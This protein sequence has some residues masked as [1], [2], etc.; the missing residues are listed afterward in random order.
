MKVS[1][2]V[3]AYQAE[4]TLAACLDSLRAQ[5]MDDIE[6]LVIDDG[7]TDRTGGIADRVADADARVR[8]IHQPNRGVS[9]AR[10]AGILAAAG[11]Y[12]A[13]ADADDT[14]PPDA[15]QRLVTVA[16]AR[17]ADLVTGD[18]DD[19]RTTHALPPD[20]SREEMLSA[21]VRCDGRYNAVW[22]HLYRR[23][24][25]LEHRLTLPEGIR[26]GEDVLF[27]LSATLAARRIAHTPQVVYHY[28]EQPDSAMARSKSGVMAAH[29]PMLDAM[30]ALLLRHRIKAAHYRDFLELHAGLR[31]RD[32]Q[33]ALLPDDLRRVNRGI[34]P[35]ALPIRQ[36]ALWGMAA[37]GLGGTLCRRIQQGM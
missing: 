35:M 17:E 3:P 33:R 11:E 12:I 5:T 22:A 16:D 29:V 7:S 13:F 1:V 31:H 6:V 36:L 23:A 32:G 9:A 20:I 27:N 24:F 8:V 19:G 10:N 2:I 37:L 26:I 28:A 21:L 4:A 18:Y 30:D 14:L 15:L 25:L 34:H